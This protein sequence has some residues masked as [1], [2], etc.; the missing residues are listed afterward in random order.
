MAQFEALT[1]DWANNSSINYDIYINDF[2]NPVG[3][4]T[5][6][7]GSNINIISDAVPRRAEQYIYGVNQS[8]A[9]QFNIIISSPNPKSRAELDR[10]MS[11]LIQPVPQY[12]SVNQPDMEFYRYHGFFTNPQTVST[13]NMLLGLQ[14][15]F[16][17][18]SPFAFTFPKTEKLNITAPLNYIFNNESGDIN[19][20]FP[21]LIIR[22]ANI[23]QA[24]SIINNSDNGRE[25]RFN[26]ASPF[27]NGN[28]IIT[29][30]NK[31]QIIQSSDGFSRQRFDQFNLNWLRFIRGANNLRITG[32]ADLEICYEFARRIGA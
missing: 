8:N 17:V 19:Y 28:E 21:K 2:E 10:I 25:F 22:P 12:L 26:F 15:T 16:V 14:F 13:S 23:T 4:R 11:W 3:W 9:Q 30:D 29:V 20:L 18:T 31:L 6:P 5:E 27:P 32:N 24:F 1:F 7:A